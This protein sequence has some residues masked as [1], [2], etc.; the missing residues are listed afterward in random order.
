VALADLAAELRDARGRLDALETDD[1]TTDLRAVF[2]WSYHRLSPLAARMFRLLGLH[3]GPDISA[4]AAASVAGTTL[5]AARAA[6]AELTGTSL[7]AEDRSGRFGCH[8]LLRA[9]AAERAAADETAD[10]REKA[11]SRLLDHYVRTAQAGCARLYPGRSQVQPSPGKPHV[12]PEEFKTYEAVLEWFAAENRVLRAV[13]ALAFESGHDDACWTLAWCWSPILLRSGQMPAVAALQRTSLACALRLRDPVALAHVHY[14][15][16][17]VSERLGDFE[18]GHAHLA[19]ALDLFAMLGDEVN[20]AQTRHGLSALLNRQGRYAEALEHAKEALRLRRSF[21]TPAMAAYSENAVGWLYA[22]L[23]QYAEALRHCEHA[24]DLHRES[25]SRTGAADT[26]D[27]IAF[28]YEQLGD[29]EQALAYYEQALDIYRG[30]GDPEGESRGLI[31]LGDVQ[32]A[33]GQRAAAER[34]WQQAAE[35]LS[36]IGGDT[37]Q[38]RERL[39][40]LAA[41]GATGAG[42]AI[43]A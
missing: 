13:H 26:L 18:E 38:V 34:S 17:H 7:L 19:Q 36:R 21:A 35:V 24:L 5:A 28:V 31:M 32:F 1:V 2:S 8:E 10:Q 12:T 39:G 6:L 16:G 11:R 43:S 27:S 40:K 22:H 33:A 15:L 9:Y 20:I 37:A 30:I 14:E 41:A 42:T 23:G 3:P 4:A 25:G 29:T